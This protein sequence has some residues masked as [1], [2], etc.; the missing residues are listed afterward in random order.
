MMESSLSGRLSAR[1]STRTL[2]PPVA[3]RKHTQQFHGSQSTFISPHGRPCSNL[4]RSCGGADPELEIDGRGRREEEREGEI[5]KEREGRREAGRLKIKLTEPWRVLSDRTA[6]AHFRHSAVFMAWSASQAQPSVGCWPDSHKR[7]HSHTNTLARTQ[8]GEDSYL[9]S[10]SVSPS[11][12]S[13]PDCYV[14]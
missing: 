12:L 14:I 4:I 3:L 13:A 11:P 10:A 8:R 6:R 1:T 9:R 2:R 5:G 7:T